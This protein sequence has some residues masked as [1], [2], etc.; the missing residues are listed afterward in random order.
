MSSQEMIDCLTCPKQWAID[1]PS[2]IRKG[3]RLHDVLLMSCHISSN[4]ISCRLCNPS[5]HQS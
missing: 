1:F 2:V 4:P 3:G 5:F